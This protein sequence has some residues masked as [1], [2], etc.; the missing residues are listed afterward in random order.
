MDTSGTGDGP[1][2]RSA[3]GEPDA[4]VVLQAAAPV[5][6]RGRPTSS[7]SPR[8]RGGR[9]LAA[10][11]RSAAGCARRSPPSSRSRSP[12][13]CARTWPTVSRAATGPGGRGRAGPWSGS[14]AR[15]CACRPPRSAP[16]AAGRDRAAPRPRPAAGGG[17]GEPRDGRRAGGA[18]PGRRGGRAR[19]AAR[20]RSS[21]WSPRTPCAGWGPDVAHVARFDED[22]IVTVGDLRL[23]GAPHRRRG[24]PAR[25]SGR[26]RGSR[27]PAA[28]PASTTTPRCAGADPVSAGV[29]PDGLGCGVAAPIRAGTGCGA[30]SSRSGSSAASPFTEADERRL[31]RFAE[32]VGL[33]VTNAEVHAPPAGPGGHRPA[34]RPRQPPRRSRSAWRR[35]SRARAP[36]RPPLSLVLLDLDHFKGSTTTTA[37]RRATPCWPRSARRLRASAAPGDLVARVGRRGVRVAHARDRRAGGRGG[38]PSARARRVAGRPFAPVGAPHGL[39]RRRA[40]WRRRATAGDAL[41]P[42][43]RRPLLGQGARPRPR[44]PLLARGGRGALA[45]RRSCA[46][47]AR[48]SRSRAIRALAP[49]GGRQGP[50]HRGATPSASPSWPRRSPSALGWTPERARAAR[51]RPGAR[52]RQDRACPTTSSSSPTADARRSTS[53]SAAHAALGARDRQPT[54]SRPSRWRGCAATTSAGTAAAT[55]TALAGR[56]DPRGRAHPGPGRRVGRHDL[57]AGVAARPPPRG[58]WPS[59]RRRRHP[60]LAP[61]RRRPSWPWRPLTPPP[62]WTARAWPSAGEAPERTQSMLRKTVQ[63]APSLGWCRILRGHAGEFRDERGAPVAVRDEASVRREASA[64]MRAAAFQ[65]RREGAAFDSIGTRLG[66]NRGAARKLVQKEVRAPRRRVGHRGAPPP[67]RRGPDGPL[68]GALRARPRPVTSTPSTASSGRRSASRACSGWTAQWAARATAPSRSCSTAPTTSPR[69]RAGPASRPTRRS[70]SGCWTSGRGRS[71]PAS[72]AGDRRPGH[73]GRGRG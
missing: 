18:A 57:A 66:V 5:R 14:T 31:E 12:Q 40:T 52:R 38:R 64:R 61:G 41:P 48:P 68:A 17:G 73:R 33:A 13:M 47:S 7:W 22:A 60:V 45:R 8:T 9:A 24:F 50:L 62:P 1:L 43:R 71:A 42:R 69:S 63:V 39:G 35:R 70:P 49:R 37:T 29:V 54:S 10:G 11:R 30:A 34:D 16:D 19:R 32:L 20:T 53:R 28:P 72:R 25:A 59:A 6:T 27:A 46:P 51:G 36:P 58:A 23:G 15:W 26:S 55:P 65:M 44:V 56:G 67:A 2:G 4:I 21:P 3:R